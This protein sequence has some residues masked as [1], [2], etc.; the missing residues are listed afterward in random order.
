[1][2]TTTT[3]TLSAA[4]ETLRQLEAERSRHELACERSGRYAAQVGWLEGAV[5]GAIVDLRA[6]KDYSKIV[7][8]LERALTRLPEVG[9]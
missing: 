2:S 6:G 5:Q 4:A 7:R 9:R 3:R 8:S 1:M